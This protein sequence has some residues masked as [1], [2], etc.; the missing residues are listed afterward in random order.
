MPEQPGF[1]NAL[2]REH[3]DPLIFRAKPCIFTVKFLSDSFDGLL[4][5]DEVAAFF[6]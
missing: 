5:P 4:L 1:F 6:M 2:A 3:C